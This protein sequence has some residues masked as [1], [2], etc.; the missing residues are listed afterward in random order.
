M[1]LSQGGKGTSCRKEGVVYLIDCLLCEKEEGRTKTAYIGE[2]S[3]SCHERLKEHMWLFVHKKDGDPAKQEANSVLWKHSKDEHGGVMK[4]EDWRSKITSTHLTA[5]NRQVTEAVL[6]SRGKE[7]TKLLNNKQEFG[8]NL[9]LE[10][11]VMRGDQVLGNRNE[12]R[13]RGGQEEAKSENVKVTTQIASITP[14][15]IVTT[16]IASFASETKE[17]PEATG[18]KEEI[19]EMNGGRS[20]GLLGPGNEWYASST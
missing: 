10:V 13:K 16:Q 5:L 4:V 11:V 6:I 9:L 18:V 12:K 19:V 3:R 14:K 7:G 2:T 17:A 1:C 15:V 8:A 20:G